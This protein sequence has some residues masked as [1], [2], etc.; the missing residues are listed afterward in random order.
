[1]NSV[2]PARFVQ[3][4]ANAFRNIDDQGGEIQLRLSPPE[5]GSL[6]MEVTVRNGVMTARLEAENNTARSL[7]LD[8]LPALRE[9]LS[10]QNIKVDRFDVDVRQDGHGQGSANPQSDFTGSR[11]NSPRSPNFDRTTATDNQTNTVAANQTT[12]INTADKGTINIVV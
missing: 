8:N 3:R 9:R 10:A 4:V 7:L 2:D 6:K 5:L 11:Q 12:S 1:M